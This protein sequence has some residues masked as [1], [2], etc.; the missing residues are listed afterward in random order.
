M[1]QVCLSVVMSGVLLAS[2]THV[3]GCRSQSSESPRENAALARPDRSWIRLD[4]TVV[5]TAPES[6][7]LDFGDGVVTVEMDDW[8]R[9]NEA[10]PMRANDKVI[11]YGRIDQDLHRRKAVEAAGVYVE[12]L[13]TTFFA[14]AADEESVG[15]WPRTDIQLGRME[16][17][18]RIAAISGKLVELDTGAGGKVTIDVSQLGYDPLDDEGFQQLDVGDRIRVI[19]QLR[20]AYFASNSLIA[21][22]I[23]SVQQPGQKAG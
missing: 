15:L 5:S 19:G 9:A 12:S 13:G 6:F 2:V 10:R 20:S 1:T 14:S 11:V 4:G 7:E 3:A 17:N 21:E 8:D 18:G 22:R 16:V 23:V